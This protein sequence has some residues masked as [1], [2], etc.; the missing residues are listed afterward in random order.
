MSRTTLGARL[1]ETGWRE[2][3]QGRGE[4][5]GGGPGDPALTCRSR[6]WFSHRSCRKR[7]MGC[8]MVTTAL[9]SR[10]SLV[11]SAAAWLPSPGW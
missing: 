11:L 1:K 6:L 10:S 2:G 9:I 8:M 7:R 3:A 5:G 4:R